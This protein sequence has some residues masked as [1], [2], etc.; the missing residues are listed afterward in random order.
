MD[1]ATAVVCGD[2]TLGEWWLK[3][4]AEA[5]VKHGA[6]YWCATMIVPTGRPFTP[7]SSDGDRDRPISPRSRGQNPYLNALIGT[8]R[9]ECWIMF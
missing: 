1:G 9:R 2:R 4:M 3:Q 6:I 7:N 8:L 5:S